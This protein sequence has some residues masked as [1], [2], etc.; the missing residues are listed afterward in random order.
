MLQ[1]LVVQVPDVD[2]VRAVRSHPVVHELHEPDV[3]L[4]HR[5][6][7][8]SQKT[9]LKLKFVLSVEETQSLLLDRKP[10]LFL[11]LCMLQ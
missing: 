8:R 10:D 7:T 4:V 2:R 5:R 3:A 11:I 1:F 9:L 6:Q